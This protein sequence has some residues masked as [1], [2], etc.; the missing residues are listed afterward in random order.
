MLYCLGAGV[1]PGFSAE[2]VGNWGGI[3]DTFHKTPCQHKTCT[4]P[5][6][7]LNNPFIIA[8]RIEYGFKFNLE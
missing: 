7:L 3:S 8:L 6:I 2:S 4:K 1:H 5:N